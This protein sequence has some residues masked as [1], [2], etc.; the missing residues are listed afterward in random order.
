M[1][2]TMYTPQRRRGL[3]LLELTLV[4]SLLVVV[5]AIVVPRLAGSAAARRLGLGANQ[6]R[7]VWTK[8]HNQAM[9]TGDP[10]QFLYRPGTRGFLVVAEPIDQQTEMAYQQAVSLLSSSWLENEDQVGVNPTTEGFHIERLPFD[11]TFVDASVVASNRALMGGM[12]LGGSRQR[13][14]PRPRTSLLRPTRLLV[15]LPESP[16]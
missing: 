6:I 1:I 2:D 15:S 13:Q 7:A 16:C 4:M 10:Q 14:R 9:L 8:A 11:I 12:S 5:F 3:T